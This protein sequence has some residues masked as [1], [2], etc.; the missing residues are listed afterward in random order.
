MYPHFEFKRN[1]IVGSKTMN[2]RILIRDTTSGS[3]LTMIPTTGRT[4]GSAIERESE[5]TSS[6]QPLIADYL[7]PLGS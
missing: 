5:V 4:D 2:Q 7:S 3:Q 1:D 6:G